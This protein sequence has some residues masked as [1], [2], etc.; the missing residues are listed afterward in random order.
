MLTERFDHPFLMTQALCDAIKALLSVTYSLDQHG[1]VH[2][3]DQHLIE[4]IREAYISAE[5]EEEP[6]GPL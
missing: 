6:E 5:E 1:F 4:D 2:Y 3:L